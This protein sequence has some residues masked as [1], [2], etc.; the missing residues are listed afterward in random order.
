MVGWVM[1]SLDAIAR[2][3]LPQS[4]LTPDNRAVPD[5]TARSP[6][7]YRRAT[8]KSFSKTS[9]RS[10]GPMVAVGFNPRFYAPTVCVASRRPN[11]T[12]CARLNRRYATK[13]H[14]ATLPWLESH[15]YQQHLATRGTAQ[16]FQRHEWS[17]T[18]SDA[19]RWLSALF[20][21]GLPA[22]RARE[23]LR[24]VFSKPATRDSLT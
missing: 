14:S 23:I 15:G 3:R 16:P 24:A 19:I 10:D 21:A 7:S 17:L 4:P 6:H 5:Q 1:S 18:T 20:P 12:T 9:S 22:C 2:R 13:P 8:T 11:A